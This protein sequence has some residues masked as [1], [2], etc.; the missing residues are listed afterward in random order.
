MVTKNIIKN[1]CET[2]YRTNTYK[3]TIKN[4]KTEKYLLSKNVLQEVSKVIMQTQK[5]AEKDNTQFVKLKDNT[6]KKL[7]DYGV[8]DLPMLERVGHIRENILSEE[9]AKKLGFST[10]NKHFHN[11]GVKTYLEIINAMDNATSIYQYTDDS[12]HFII[13]TPLEIDGVKTIVPV[14]IEQIGI[15]NNISINFNKIKTTFIPDIDYINKLLKYKKIK[16][17]FIG[18]NYQQKSLTNDNIPQS[19]KD[20][21]SDIS[22]KYTM[23]D[24]K[25]NTQN[26]KSRTNQNKKS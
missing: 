11:L 20:V 12:K 24:T 14:Y 23:Q 19:N 21:K 15:Y 18:D 10:K 3:Q 26:C 1:K 25:N 9:L 16:E 5:E 7:V 6:I 17:I 13:E 22:T 2:T 8:K 4:A